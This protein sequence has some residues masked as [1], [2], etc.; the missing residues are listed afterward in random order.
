MKKTS[1][2]NDNANM[3]A[4]TDFAKLCSMLA[5]PCGRVGHATSRG[6][7]GPGFAPRTG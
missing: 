6:A 4:K 7:R 2:I 3:A 1:D 5:C